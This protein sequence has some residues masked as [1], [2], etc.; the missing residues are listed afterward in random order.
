MPAVARHVVIIGGGI[1]GLAAAHALTE[2]ARRN[3]SGGAGISCTLIEA[4]P[5]L[6]GKILTDRAD[7][8]V[9]EGGADSFLAQKPWGI[10]LCRRLGLTDN[11]MTTNPEH[12]KTFVLLQGRLQELPEGVV[13]G[14]P[15]KLGP[16]LRTQLLSWPAKFRIAAEFFI[17]PSCHAEDES[18]ATFFRRRLGQEALDRMIEPLLSGIYTADADQLSLLAT[19]P[20]FRDMELRHGGLLRAMLVAKWREWRAGETSAAATPFVTLRDGLCHLV[21]TLAKRLERTT[22]LLNSP[23]LELRPQDGN[24][25]ELIMCDRSL[26][27]DAVILA[28]PAY[29]AAGLLAP[30]DRVLSEDLAGIPYAGSVTVSLGFRK[31]DLGHKLDGYGFVVPRVENRL[32]MASTWTSSKWDHRA[33]DDAVLIRCYLGGEG[34]EAVLKRT[35]AE[36]I[37]LAQMELRLILGIQQSPVLARVYRWPR[38]MPQYRVGHLQRLEAIGGRLEHLPGVFLAG[39]GYRGVGIPDCIRDGMAAAENVGRYFD[40]VMPTFV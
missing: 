21:Q 14:V 1:T 5:R 36:I 2:S 18:L 34:R 33:P 31:H 16:F 37:E 38:A 6:G 39:A 13:M 8:F 35:D 30:V 12:R 29:G 22:V 28:T 25:Y 40:K 20:R 3:S 26:S 10:D 7:G 23:V 24:G 27:A 9:I 19:F 4:S 15:G 11:L 32:A 17:P